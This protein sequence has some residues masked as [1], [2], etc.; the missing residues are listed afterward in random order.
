MPLG[1]LI[2]KQVIALARLG[3]KDLRS[4]DRR[5][6]GCVISANLRKEEGRDQVVITERHLAL[7]ERL[8]EFEVALDAVHDLRRMLTAIQDLHIVDRQNR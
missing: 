3:R 6:Q 1:G 8:G 2:D 5:N 4:Q 7:D